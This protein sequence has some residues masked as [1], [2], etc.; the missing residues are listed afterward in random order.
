MP[1]IHGID[2]SNHQGVALERA[3]KGIRT[4]VDWAYGIGIDL[5]CFK[6]SEGRQSGDGRYDDGKRYV[7]TW[8]QAAQEWPFPYTGVYHWLSNDIPAEAQRDNAAKRIGQLYPNECIQLDIEEGGLDYGEIRHAIDV[9]EETW[10]GRVFYYL[11][12]YMAANAIDRLGVP[13]EKWWW[14]AYIPPNTI[15]AMM[16]RHHPPFPPAVWQWGGGGQGLFCPLVA[17]RIDANQIIDVEAV[18]A[19]CGYTTNTPVQPPAPVVTGK[20]DLMVVIL[21]PRG[22]NARFLAVMGATA[23][24]AQVAAHVEWLR[25]EDEMRPF[26]DNGVHVVECNVTDLANVSVDEV[27]HGDAIEWAESHFRRVTG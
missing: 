14:P 22:A 21:A 5:V 15:E 26:T 23:T 16:A 2:I 19:R 24:G 10:P 1:P 8:R 18:R 13:S 17:G 25:T 6:I 9:W 20:D 12:R 4:I 11:G 3:G 27:P 7:N